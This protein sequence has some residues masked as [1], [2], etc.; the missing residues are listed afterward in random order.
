MSTE[1]F[2]THDP[3]TKREWS[4]KWG[5]CERCERE[6]LLYRDVAYGISEPRWACG[7]CLKPVARGLA[8]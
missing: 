6:T 1:T 3:E 4:H 8:D 5:R 2:E 7:H